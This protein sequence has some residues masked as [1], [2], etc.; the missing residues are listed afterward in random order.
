MPVSD[1]IS[2]VFKQDPNISYSVFYKEKLFD[3]VR[4]YNKESLIN[5]KKIF[6]QVIVDFYWENG[7]L[8]NACY[9]YREE[10]TRKR[11]IKG[12][13]EAMND[14]DLNDSHLFTWDKNEKI[15][16]DNGTIIVRPLWDFLMN[17]G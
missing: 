16:V 1:Y 15:K 4:L 14:L 11:E 7:M 17:M 12:L 2:I 13:V 10:G 9:D 3:I 6:Q 8:I 5:K